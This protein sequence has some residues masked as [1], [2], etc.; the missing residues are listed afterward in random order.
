MHWD[1]S[2]ADRTSA[3]FRNVS[4]RALA[5]YLYRRGLGSASLP[6]EEGEGLL[7]AN[8]NVARVENLASSSAARAC[9]SIIV[10]VVTRSST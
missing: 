5:R 4:S 2:R 1:E 8:A 9:I 3:G 7:D 10:R 6:Q